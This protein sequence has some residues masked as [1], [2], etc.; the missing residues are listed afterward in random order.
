MQGNGLG[1][2]QVAQ[3]RGYADQRLRKPDQPFDASNRRV[4][5]IVQYVVKAGGSGGSAGEG[6]GK[7]EPAKTEEPPPHQ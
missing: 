7:Q 5:V 6:E 2:E 1:P 3:V 4:S